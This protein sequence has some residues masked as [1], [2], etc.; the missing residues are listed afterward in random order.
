MKKVLES[1]LCL[2]VFFIM[3]GNHPSLFMKCPRADARHTYL[4][5]RVSHDHRQPCPPACADGD[6]PG[7]TDFRYRRALLRLSSQKIKGRL[8]V[9]DF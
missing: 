2:I 3:V 5:I 7:D 9:N 8:G 1:G 4:G 6:P